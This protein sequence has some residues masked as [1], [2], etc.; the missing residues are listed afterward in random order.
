MIT[1]A[2]QPYTLVGPPVRVL[3]LDPLAVYSSRTIYL[4]IC[5]SSTIVCKKKE[6]I[7]KGNNLHWYFKL[8]NTTY[9]ETKRE[10]VLET[11]QQCF[12][13]KVKYQEGP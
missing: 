6:L 9:K 12:R 11:K 1:K 7:L 4:S 3:V 10:V 13:N 8:S 2:F 5:N